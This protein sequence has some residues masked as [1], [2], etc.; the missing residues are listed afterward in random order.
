MIRIVLSNN[1]KISQR[2]LDNIQK[3]VG[4]KFPDAYLSLIDNNGGKCYDF[5]ANKF[6]YFE[7]HSLESHKTESMEITRILRLYNVNY[8]NDTDSLS[9]HGHLTR[10][11]M[12]YELWPFAEAENGYTLLFDMSD[13]E[14]PVYL[15]MNGIGFDWKDVLVQSSLKEFLDAI[16]EKSRDV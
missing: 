13:G 7:Y 8:E 11:M 4:Y 16:Y 15:F 5:K 9:S 10:A 14:H 2:L 12:P 3:K 6:N 1:E